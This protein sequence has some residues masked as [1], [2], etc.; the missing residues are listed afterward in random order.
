[1][2]KGRKGRGA[3]SAA[4]ESEEDAE[5]REDDGEEDLQEGA[6]AAVRHRDLKAGRVGVGVGVGV[7]IGTDG[8]GG[9]EPGDLSLLSLPLS[10]LLSGFRLLKEENANGFRLRFT[11]PVGLG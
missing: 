6:A 8:C 1:V 7:G 4:A 5:G 2:A 9:V 10:S 11:L 3:Y